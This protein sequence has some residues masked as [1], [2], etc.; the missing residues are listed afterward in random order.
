V[1]LT[2]VTT[3]SG[4]TLTIAEGWRQGRGAYGGLTIAA[5]LRAIEAHVADPRRTVRSLT[6]DLPGPTLP[7]TADIVVETLR[8]GTNLTVARGALHQAGA[9]TTHVVA[10]LAADREAL[11]G[12]TLDRC[13]LTP[14]AA[15]PW[16]SV[17][18]IPMVPD[19][20]WP[21]FV[22]NFELRLVT[23]MPFAGGTEATVTGYVRARDPGPARDA[24][25]LAAMI[26]VWWPSL[27]G[28]MTGPRPMATIAFTL[29]LFGSV[30]D[31]DPEVPLLYHGTVPVVSHGYF[32]ETRELWTPSGTLL[33]RNHQ[34]FAIIK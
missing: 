29:E 22:S 27:F 34:T 18:P 13:D 7:G 9:V 28:R 17:A 12:A 23:G 1:T 14:P 26:D 6:A 2:D 5:T 8:S 15:P 3:P 20:G 33:A 16:Q 4:A 10:I 31:A 11:A 24:A 30:R 19:H 21:E 25:Y 32:V